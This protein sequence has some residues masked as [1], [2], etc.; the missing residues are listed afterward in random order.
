MSR[1]ASGTVEFRGTPARW[2]ARIS[3][4][5]ASGKTHRPWVDLGRPDLKD[6]PEDKATAK[7]LA[8]KRAKVARKGVFVGAERVQAERGEPLADYEDRW[9]SFIERDPDLAVKTVD[10]YKSS[11]TSIK[12]AF[13]TKLVKDVTPLAVREWIWKRRNERAISTVLNECIALSRFFQDAISENWIVGLANPMHDRIVREAKPKPEH[14]DQDD[15]VRYT[16]AQIEALLA[17]DGMPDI[18]FGLILVDVLSGERDGEEHGLQFLHLKDPRDGK[19]CLRIVQQA[20]K[21]TVDEGI[22]IAEPKRGSKRTIP[23]HSQAAT[24]LAWWRDEG[25]ES[26]VGREPTDEDF[27]F[28]D[29]AGNVCR[30]R[31]AEMLR[32][33][34]KVAG[35]PVEF[36]R[37]DG[38]E[39]AFTMNALRRTFASLLG[40]LE[41][42]GELLDE[43]LGH[44]PKSVRARHYQGTW[45][46][47]KVRAVER[48]QLVLPERPGVDQSSQQLS[49][50]EDASCVPFTIP[51]QFGSGSARSTGVIPGLQNR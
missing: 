30:P 23:L 7:R 12:T 21:E 5:D 32:K 4:K 29:S 28:P 47:R 22:H 19:A 14:R 40:D 48:L 15:I 38:T 45:F 34:A 35:L 9:F 20:V 25:W 39:E 17:A 6:T 42:D 51:A 49:Q 11:W 41:V 37:Q 44:T 33:W 24:W 2:H 3:V 10:R 43:L 46:E 50:G 26:Y 1:E 27:I 8:F 13:G 31:D 18:D 36:I 16:K